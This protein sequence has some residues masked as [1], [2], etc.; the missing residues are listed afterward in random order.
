MTITKIMTREEY[1]ETLERK[2]KKLKRIGD[3]IEEKDRFLANRL[4]LLIRLGEEIQ[5]YRDQHV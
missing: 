1:F 2:L 5:R 3:R 4:G